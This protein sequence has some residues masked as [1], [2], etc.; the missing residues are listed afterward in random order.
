MSKLNEKDTELY[1]HEKYIINLSAEENIFTDD[2]MKKIH[3]LSNGITD[4]IDFLCLQYLSDPI[5]VKQNSKIYLNIKIIP[6]LIKYGLILLISFSLI[7]GIFFFFKLNSENTNHTLKIELPKKSE[8]KVKLDENLLIA[9]KEVIEPP[10]EEE[11]SES[12]TPVSP[13][14]ENDSHVEISD[15]QNVAKEELALNEN[16]EDNI[17]SEIVK[18]SN[19][20]VNQQEGIEKQ[21]ELKNSKRDI[22]WL[23]S[24][25]P[26]KYVLQLISAIKP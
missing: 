11:L 23:V 7:G 16:P 8:N 13:E 26:D 19:D 12:V 18:N 24:Q 2:V 22:N 21:E 17:N 14:I 20:V 1:I 9:L 5:G 15:I 10:V 4:R 25:E 3:H 6:L